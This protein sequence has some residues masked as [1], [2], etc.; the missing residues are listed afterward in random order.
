MV[1]AGSR[2]AAPALTGKVD[3]GVQASYL[4]IYGG[5]LRFQGQRQLQHDPEKRLRFSE[6]V[7]LKQR[8]EIVI[9]FNLTGS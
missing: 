7:M 3:G 6:K 4:G 2:P 8:D 1:K 9:R 5:I